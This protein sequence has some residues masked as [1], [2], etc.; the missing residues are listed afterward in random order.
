MITILL[1][2]NSEVFHNSPTP[3]N[4]AVIGVVAEGSV[5]GALALTT[6]GIYVRLNAGVIASLPQSETAY[7]HG[8]AAY[9]ENGSRLTDNPH[10]YGTIG[11]QYWD[12]GFRAALS[13]DETN[14]D[15]IDDL[16][17]EDE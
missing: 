3:L 13:E 16:A 11:H 5:A 6:E 9:G 1:N 8:Y 12:K 10:S 2:A 15:D 17:V 4:M 14:Q 7:E